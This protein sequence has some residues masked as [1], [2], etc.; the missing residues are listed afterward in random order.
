MPGV[1]QDQTALYLKDMYKAEREG[2]EEIAP[3]YDK[4]YKVIYAAK[5]AGDKITQ[6]LGAGALN[7]HTVEGQKVE[8]KS[9]VQG[10]EQLVKYHTYSAGIALSKEAGEDTVKLGNLLK[11]LA[12]SW[13]ISERIV[14]EEM[15]SRIFNQ[16]GALAGDWIFNG[17]H[18]G[19]TD[20]SGDLLY[21]N[22]PL[23]NLTGNDRASKGG[24]TYFNSIAGLT[25]GMDSFE[26]VYNLITATNNRDERDRVIKN[27]IDTLL[28]QV[29]AD[30][31]TADK[32]L[33]T[34]KGLP[35][36]QLNDRNPF[37][38]ICNPIHWDYLNDDA[39]YLGKRQ[40]NAFQFHE[41]QKSEL[42]FFRDEENLGYKVSINMRIGILIKNWRVWARGGGSST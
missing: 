30:R 19:N 16:G 1:R 39:F 5:G 33:Q 21:D 35:E 6:I 15:G 18:T 32:I 28:T 10:W 38:K 31:W 14:K 17:T 13:G 36:T 3:V 12:N 26:T 7:R 24:D 11:D 2:Y 23:F 25:L 4:I 42:R 27:P 8:F 20:G 41:R 40:S 9:P 37:Y 34:S 29:G 22:F